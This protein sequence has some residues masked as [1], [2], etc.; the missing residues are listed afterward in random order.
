M[1]EFSKNEKGEL[2]AFRTEIAKL[3]ML[4]R[5][6]GK[7]IHFRECYPYELGE[8]DR[9]L[10]EKFISDNLTIEEVEEYKNKLNKTGT[11]NQIAFSNYIS[12][13]LSLKLAE[14]RPKKDK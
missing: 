8:E 13:M 5:E 7:T 11:K 6:E 1:E 12:N 9:K 4:E 14:K 10:Y 2:E 3:K